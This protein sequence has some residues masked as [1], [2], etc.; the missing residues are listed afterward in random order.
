MAEIEQ[1]KNW[2]ENIVIQLG[3]CPFAAKVFY[4]NQILFQ[5]IEFDDIHTL[6]QSINESIQTILDIDSTYTTAL[7]VIT[8][9]L[10]TFD[11]YLEAF[12]TIEER[13]ANDQQ[14]EHIQLASFH[15]HY[16]FEG[17]APND[18]SN[19]TNRSPYPI[20]HIL[21][22]DLVEKAIEGYPD[23]HSV[24]SNNIKKMNELGMKKIKQLFDFTRSH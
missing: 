4:E 10:S 1:T 15:P 17:T 22:T 11:D 24:P 14:D 23:I 5:S 7:L 9:G 6:G 20:I 3:L 21:R 12:Y 18:P 16:Q 8:S 2:L 13:I 19:S